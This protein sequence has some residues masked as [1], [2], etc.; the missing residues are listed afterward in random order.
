MT[1]FKNK[2]GE[3]IQ[4]EDT[5]FASGGEGR[6]HKIISPAKYQNFCAKIYFD[7]INP[8]KKV[9]QKI[10]ER[11]EKIEFMVKNKPQKLEESTW[12]ICWPNDL[13]FSENEFV[14]FI[15]P[16]AFENSVELFELTNL[17]INQDLQFDWS[18]FDRESP[19][20]IKRRFKLNSNIALA[21]HNLHESQKYVVVD[22]K[23]Q[24]F[25]VAPDGKV[26]ILDVDTIQISNNG[27]VLFPSKAMTAEYLPPESANINGNKIDISWVRFIL[28]VMFYEV[29]YGIHP[30][31]GAF[32]PPYDNFNTL[33]ERI[34]NGLFPFGEK[35]NYF[36]GVPKQH[37]YFRKTP[38][39]LQHL[40]VDTFEHGLKNA[41]DRP[42]AEAWGQTFFSC[43]KS[44]TISAQ[45]TLSNTQISQPTNNITTATTNAQ[46]TTTIQTYKKSKG[47]LVG[48][49][50]S[51]IATIILVIIAIN[52][53]QDRAKY[54]SK[55]YNERNL[56]EEY[57]SKVETAY[58]LN[59]EK[60]EE[61]T[62]LKSLISDF[63]SK[64]PIE[65]TDIKFSNIDANS[66]TI[67]DF[68]SKLYSYKV[69]YLHSKIYY[70]SFLENSKD[71]KLYIK[72]FRPNGS[73]KTG[74]SSPFGYSTSIEIYVS[75][76]FA[77][78]QS[79]ELIG[80]GTSSGGSYES[81]SYIYEI[82]YNGKCISSKTF[83]I[84]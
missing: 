6:V 22:M 61:I 38:E 24:N 36:K 43:V 26:S 9:P 62:K 31:T 7:C 48:L 37:F 44:N 12:R 70:N 45:P 42:S 63:A 83:Y 56:N 13:V 21:V 30:F 64:N 15:M 67:N 84:Y 73:L 69:K 58:E 53:S 32:K 23:P 18:K 11:E 47:L 5:P 60:E 8:K 2:Q 55:Y 57:K 20:G 68:G 49:I 29:L 54:K 52:L 34:E 1:T 4:L 77:T 10:K 75:G 81:G 72:V 3:I 51:L 39:Q 80:W 66:S 76:S 28:S 27:S 33:R 17:K 59:K 19:E 82:W 50:I 16:L 14:G 79:K 41:H 46:Q 65:I 78:N 25:L 35:D 74:S 71:I 40:F